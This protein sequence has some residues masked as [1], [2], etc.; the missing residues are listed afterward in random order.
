[1]L[2]GMLP[3]RRRIVAG[4]GCLTLA[5]LFTGCGCTTTVTPPAPAPAPAPPAKPLLKDWPQPAVT[6]LM[7]ADQLGYL[8]PC[9]CSPSQ[10]GGLARRAR[11]EQILR[12][13]GWAVVGLDAGGTLKR[14]RRQ[15]QVKFESIAA[16]LKEIGYQAIGAGA[17]ELFLGPDYLLTQ[18]AEA[19]G[20]PL[21]GLLVSANVSLFDAPEIGV[22]KRFTTF[23]AGGKKIAVTAVLGAE[24]AAEVAPAGV[25]TNITVQPAA[26]ALTALLP[27]MQA[28]NPDLLV[29]LAHGTLEEARAWA[30]AFPQFQI[31]LAAG[32]PE[33]PDDR[34][35]TIGTTWLLQTGQKGKHIGVLGYY[36]AETPP[37]RWEYVDLDNQRFE[38]DPRMDR[39]MRNYQQQLQDLALARSDELSL[40]LPDGGKFVGA[41]V[42]GECHKQ[43]YAKWT[44]SKHAHALES[45]SRGRKGMEATWVSRV[46]DP[47]C[48][49]C[50]VTGWDPQNV[51]RYDSGYLDETTTAHLV[52]QQC[53]NCHGPGNK[54]TD[55][56][57]QYRK[58][59]KSVTQDELI[60]A[61][62]GLKLNYKT[63][64]KLVCSKCHDYENSPNFKFEKYWDEVK[65][66]W[67][68]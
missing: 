51:L 25:K 33:E 55:L 14:S 13:R 27:Q 67:K 18:F 32:G 6:F 60:A 58:D 23:E 53:E 12:D 28:S 21:A 7:S 44:K 47:E 64:E 45:L 3:T 36:P 9:G 40:P 52:G 48:L 42:C 50:H 34:P 2:F 37:F 26:D 61:R 59:L 4:L 57:R 29:L 24:R 30:K 39:L 1:M 16:G 8:E 46:H 54:H 15:D 62:A 38:N 19:D 35:E 41:K 66:P 31:V 49:A 43:A 10:S 20:V 22:P 5:A 56:E 65:H 68:D 17:A 63:A 11:L